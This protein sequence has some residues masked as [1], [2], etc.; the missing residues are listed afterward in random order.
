MDLDG[1]IVDSRASY[2][3]A[4]MNAFQKLDRL[5]T[6]ETLVT[7]VPKRLEQGKDVSDLIGNLDPKEFLNIYL[8]T[9]YESTKERS[10]LLPG[11]K[12]ALQKLSAKAKLGLVTMRFV[13]SE[14]VIDEL[15]MLNIADYF[16]H[17]LTAMDTQNPKP[18]PE[19]LIRCAQQSY[20]DLCEC[21]IV[22]D[23]VVDVE[24]GKQARMYTIAVLTGIYSRE[25]LE[26]VKPDSILKSIV[27]LPDFLRRS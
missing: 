13:P 7:E 8:R 2:Q 21:A 5:T 27:Q 15:K 12:N 1:T 3:Y 10:R 26:R 9:F 23:S 16:T 17:V 6:D 22:G 19:V 18:S 14:A 11:A 20:L 25:E 4:L 24:A